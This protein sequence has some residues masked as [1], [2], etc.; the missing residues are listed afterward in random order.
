MKK[1]HF[2]NLAYRK[3]KWKITIAATLIFIVA[4]YTSFYFSLEY[5]NVV[6][7]VLYFS[8]FGY[9]IYKNTRKNCYSYISDDRFKLRLDGEKLD[10][11]SKFIT[12]VWLDNGQ[13]HLQRINRVDSFNVSHLNPV[14]VDKLV[15]VIKE[16]QAPAV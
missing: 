11:D 7:M 1:I 5:F 4:L 14:H 15:K 12:E 2:F 16:Q 8:Y 9:E 10:V 6:S 3:Y 13:L